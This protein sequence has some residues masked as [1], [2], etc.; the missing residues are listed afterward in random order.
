VKKAATILAASAIAA[1]GIAACGSDDDDSSSSDDTAATTTAAATGETVTITA[2]PGG[3]LKFTT[4]AV[5]AKAGPTTLELD[6]PSSVPHDLVVET[7]DGSEV[8][9]TD[10]VSETKT[11]FTAD[12]SPG[13]Y[14]FY[15]DLPG[16]EESMQGKLTVK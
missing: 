8:G 2:D 4:E 13:E 1:F 15:C 9:K 10:I 11:D 3:S 16:H 5:D 14:R 12:L 6:N 7:A